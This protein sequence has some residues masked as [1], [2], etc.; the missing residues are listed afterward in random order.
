MPNHIIS[1][2]IYDDGIGG[3]V[4]QFSWSPPTNLDQSDISHY[5]V[6]VNGTNILSKT[7]EMDQNMIIV[8]YAVFSCGTH[9]VSVSAV[10]HCGRDGQKSP[11]ITLEDIVM[12]P[13]SHDRDNCKQ[14]G[15]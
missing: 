13:M 10:D 11:N 3:C 12:L 8:S 2:L 9:S 4:I 7:S 5:I 15:I 1:K 14:P 6:Y